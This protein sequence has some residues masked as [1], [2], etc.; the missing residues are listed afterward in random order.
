MAQVRWEY[1]EVVRS[2]TVVWDD[3]EI[4]RGR[5]SGRAGRRISEPAAISRPARPL[6][7]WAR[8]AAPALAVLT[9]AVSR[10]VVEHCHRLGA[11][12]RAALAAGRPTLIALPAGDRSDP[13]S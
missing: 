5:D 1:R 3:E 8:L 7:S 10:G 13:A 9:L 4:S 12:K 2:V 11:P 6:R